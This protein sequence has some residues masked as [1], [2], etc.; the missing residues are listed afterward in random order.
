MWYLHPE[1]TANQRSLA[2]GRMMLYKQGLQ[3]EAAS[4][5]KPSHMTVKVNKLSGM[6]LSITLCNESSSMSNE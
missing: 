4:S 6:R 5:V 1:K 2:A 3:G